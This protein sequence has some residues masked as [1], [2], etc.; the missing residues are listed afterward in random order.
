MKKII[1]TVL[2]SMM[3]LTACSATEDTQGE[4]ENV[5]NNDP[6]EFVKNWEDTTLTYDADANQ[7]TD[8]EIDDIIFAATKAPTGLNLQPYRIT[9]I[10]DYDTQMELALTPEVKPTE[11][12]VMFIYS[13]SEEE[14][15]PSIDVGISYGYMHAMAQAY[16][17][18]THIFGQPARML[19]DDGNPQDFG[20]PEG[21][22]PLE[23]VLVGT[24]DKADAISAA[25]SGSRIDIHNFFQAE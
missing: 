15:P 11:G 1:G 5:D 24:S 6:V 22:L 12:T 13:Y 7:P 9:V 23:F 3:L 20:I 19:A 4:G 14:N 16:G 18:G 8:S 25:T 2:A 10:T 21:Y 17:Y